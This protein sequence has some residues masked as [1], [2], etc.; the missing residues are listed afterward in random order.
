MIEHY[1]ALKLL[2]VAA[3]VA[4]GAL[5]F[6]RG[7]LML[8]DSQWGQRRPVR[9]L[10]Y[11]IDTILLAA[12]IVLTTIVHQYPFVN[13]WLTVKV[14]LLVVYIGLGTFALK[15][16]RT[17]TARATCFAA[18]LLVYLSI[19]AVA[20]T[21]D[22]LAVFHV[23]LGLVGSAQ[24]RSGEVPYRNREPGNAGDGTRAA[25]QGFHGR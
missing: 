19:A 14:V 12:A 22:P 7:V 5:F 20:R 2:H 13:A 15:R 25:G 23:H 16:G 6:V 11:A 1:A 18:A 21:H 8:L 17:K 4:S 24:T 10:S 9:H 3:V